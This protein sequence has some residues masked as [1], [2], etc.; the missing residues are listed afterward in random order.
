MDSSANFFREEAF[1]LLS[2]LEGNLL[3][4][5]KNPDNKDLLNDVFRALH[6]LKGSGSMF[7]FVELADFVHNIEG[8]FDRVRKGEVTLQEDLINLTLEAR[9][10][11]KVLLQPDKKVSS[12][13]RKKIARLTEAFARLIA[14]TAPLTTKA[15]LGR[16]KTIAEP[17]AT[18]AISAAGESKDL[19]TF[20]IRFSPNPDYFASGNN[21][22]LIMSELASM[23]SL[24]TRPVYDAVP[25]LASIDPEKCFIA[26]D[27][28][29]T[30]HHEMNAI[31]DVFLFVEDLCELK[32]EKDQANLSGAG[33]DATPSS[34]R[35][36]GQV[37]NAVRIISS[38][39]ANGR[40]GD[41]FS[42]QATV[43]GIKVDA[44]K[45]ERLISLL[46]E[47]VTIQSRINQAAE[48]RGDSELIAISQELDSLTGELRDNALKLSMLP[49]DSIFHRLQLS[50]EAEALACNRQVKF[51]FIGGDTEL[52]K[53]VLSRLYEPLTSLIG[54]CIR[55]SNE[56]TAQ[57]SAH[58]KDPVGQ[59]SISAWHSS[60]NVCVSVEDDGSFLNAPEEQNN[61]IHRIQRIIEELRGSLEV[62]LVAGRNSGFVIKLPL[63]LAIID[64]LMIRLAER[65][66]VF[67]LSLVEECIELTMADRSRHY[68]KDV[69]MV[70]GQIV[71][72][73]SLRQKFEVS[74]APPEVQ[75]VVIINQ[76][77]RRVGFAVDQVVGEYQTVIKNWGKFCSHTPGIT[78][79]TILGDG[80]IA[81]IADLPV[82]IEEEKNV[83]IQ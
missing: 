80:S 52:D 38:A 14:Q 25:D 59:I 61:E 65:L 18:S 45:L 31:R 21:P 3:D 49:I 81:L 5:S 70:R 28:T 78:G 15:S 4:L 64:G 22:L 60:G 24:T 35:Q 74:G 44:A 27:L 83:H 19:A 43:S 32:I 68:N 66:F 6:T 76:N 54:F 77:G 11:M 13:S 12:G 8:I 36:S 73:I 10:L 58:G 75:Q 55:H 2:T 37:E 63:N 26:W 40:A 56:T 42:D 41:I 30:T 17:A 9:D 34:A 57:R 39:I 71:P 62:R 7:G 53:G 82:L 50:G 51:K 23:G 29:L 69:V 47:L 1:E 16:P 72:F 33:P 67:P 79:A 48:T 20:K 46:G